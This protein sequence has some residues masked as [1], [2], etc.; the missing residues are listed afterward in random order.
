MIIETR[1]QDILKSDIKYIAHQINCVTTTAK[2][3]S[4][5][6]FKRYPNTN[7]YINK[8]RR[9][10]GETY[11][12]FTNKEDKIIFHLAGQINPGKPRSSYPDRYEDRLNYFKKCILSL[13][14]LVEYLKVEYKIKEEIIIGFPYGIGCGLAGGNWDDYNKILE[15]SKL[16]IILFKI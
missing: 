2:G 12:D 14:D 10:G 8:S 7:R 9:V 16:K 4:E 11:F 6:I 15:E 1:N 3:L 13:E 5:Q